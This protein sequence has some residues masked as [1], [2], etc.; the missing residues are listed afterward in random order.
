MSSIG[1]NIGTR[2]GTR[3]GVT[4]AKVVRGTP[5]ATLYAF[6]PKQ[7][8][9][10]GAL[11]DG[12]GRNFCTGTLVGDNVVLTAAH[13]VR[14]VDP[15][16]IRFAIGEDAS[17]PDKTFEVAEIRAN[18]LWTMDAPGHDNALLFLRGSVL[19]Y[20]TPIPISRGVLPDLAGQQVQNVGYGATEPNG[21]GLNTQRWWTTQ[22]VT[23]IDASSVVVDGRQVSSVCK[24][25]SGSPSLYRF[26]D[27]QIRIIG[28]LHGGET[29]CIGLD[30]Y[31]RID[32]DTDWLLSG[33]GKLRL[34]M[35]T[36]EAFVLPYVSVP[37]I[38]PM[39]ATV[40]WGTGLVLAG[41]LIGMLVGKRRRRNGR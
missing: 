33:G 20:A 2:G 23:Q 28:T 34:P 1:T 41:L 9:A 8:A 36:Q 6:D 12:F 4:I 29:T 32:L 39:F 35:G 24:G 38:S 5:D 14:H 19:R 13:C 17:T 18:P 30:R 10:I 21:A 37:G 3:S 16:I 40:G 7:K 27:G 26:P 15:S 22:L 31:A 11:I 25:D